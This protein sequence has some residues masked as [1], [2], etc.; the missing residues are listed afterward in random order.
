MN[1]K[2]TGFLSVAVFIALVSGYFFTSKVYIEITPE[3]SY[4]NYQL[5]QHGST[6][7]AHFKGVFTNPR[8]QMIHN[9]TILVYWDE[10]GDKEHIESLS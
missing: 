7:E 3:I 10:A 1:T 4:F 9:V 2:V 6:F 8:N 5:I